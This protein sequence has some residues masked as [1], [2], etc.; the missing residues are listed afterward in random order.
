[1]DQQA[2]RRDRR[3]RGQRGPA[4]LPSSLSPQPPLTRIRRESFDR[5]V[6]DIVTEIDAR[7]AEHLGPIEY[8]VEDIPVL[9]DDWQDGQVPLSSVVRKKGAPTRLVVFRRPVEHRCRDRADIE[10][11]VLTVVVEQVADILGIEPSQV[12]PRY[13]DED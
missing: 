13:I 4:V 2:R 6:L 1:M 5:T 9:P 7:W 8:A 12:D 10:A 11:L 3:G